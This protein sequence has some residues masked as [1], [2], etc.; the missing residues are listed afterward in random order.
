MID[1]IGIV[2][3]AADQQIGTGAAIQGVVAG[4]AGNRVGAG[5]AGSA[6]RRAGQ[7]QAFEFVGKHIIKG[8][9]DRINAAI[10]CFDDDIGRRIDLVGV[11]AEPARQRV[12]AGGAIQ[13]V[14]AIGAGNGVVQRIAGADTRGAGQLQ[15]FDVGRQ[16]EIGAGNYR[17]GTAAKRLGHHV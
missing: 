4:A 6:V 5:V 8:S 10:R 17:V 7:R 9:D 16:R 2:A 13:G 3:E 11:V 1:Q 14:V 15:I 12:V